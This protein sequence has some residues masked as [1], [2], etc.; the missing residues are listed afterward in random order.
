[1][2]VTRLG[3][4]SVLIDTAHGSILTADSAVSAIR[5]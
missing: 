1:M 2:R 4:A 3:H 5:R